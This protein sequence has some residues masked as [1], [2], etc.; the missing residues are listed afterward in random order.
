MLYGKPFKEK[1]EKLAEKHPGLEFEHG[2]TDSYGKRKLKQY[3]VVEE[4]LGAMLKY[5]DEMQI[6]LVD[7]FARFDD[8][9]SMSVTHEEFKEGLRV[10]RLTLVK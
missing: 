10:R 4:A 1:L 7:L 3:N 6:K 9:G 2:Y 5:C 8:D